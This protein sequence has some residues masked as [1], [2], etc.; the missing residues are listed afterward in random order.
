MM[1]DL[2]GAGALY[3]LKSGVS[4]ALLPPVGPVSRCVCGVLVGGRGVSTV[5]LSTYVNVALY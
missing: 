3:A 5:Y 1:D 2:N 4:G